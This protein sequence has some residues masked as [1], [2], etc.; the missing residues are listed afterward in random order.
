MLSFFSCL[1]GVFFFFFFFFL[2]MSRPDHFVQNLLYKKQTKQLLTYLLANHTVEISLFRIRKSLQFNLLDDQ[3]LKKKLRCQ[4]T[5][6]HSAII[7]SLLELFILSQGREHQM[8]MAD[9]P[10]SML[11]RV[12]FVAHFFCFAIVA[13]FA[14]L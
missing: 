6:H 3:K 12:T 1:F 13:R 2:E 11:T 8:Q 14:F 9:V 7:N 10:G 4:S 5:D